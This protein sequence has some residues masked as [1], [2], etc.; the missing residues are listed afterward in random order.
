MNTKNKKERYSGIDTTPWKVVTYS[1]RELGRF[2]AIRDEKSRKISEV[3]VTRWSGFRK[4]NYAA[5]KLGGVAI[6]A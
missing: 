6:R 3:W 2:E 5:K 1:G 4:A